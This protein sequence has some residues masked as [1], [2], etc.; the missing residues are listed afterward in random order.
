MG[1]DWL[2]IAILHLQPVLE[3]WVNYETRLLC[4]AELQRQRY[5]DIWRSTT[6]EVGISRDIIS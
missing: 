5:R 6:T 1:I 4:H 2:V 3:C